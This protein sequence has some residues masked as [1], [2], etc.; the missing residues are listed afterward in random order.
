MQKGAP[1]GAPSYLGSLESPHRRSHPENFG[2]AGFY[3]FALG[4]DGGGIGL[5]QLQSGQR[6]T[7]RFLLDLCMKRTMGVVVDQQLLSFRAEEE[8][9]EQSRGI[10]MRCVFEYAA[11]N[12]DQR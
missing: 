3:L 12:D 4:L 10:R 6:W 1:N 9:L 7:A 11:G 8:T 5:E 2:V